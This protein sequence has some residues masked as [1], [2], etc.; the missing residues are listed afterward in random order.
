MG[1]CAAVANRHNAR[2][3]YQ[4]HTIHITINQPKNTYQIYEHIHVKWTY[5]PN[6]KKVCD[7]IKY[8]QTSKQK[9]FTDI[10]FKWQCTQTHTQRWITKLNNLDHESHR[11][12][13]QFW[14][15][16][17]ETI[18][19]VFIVF[20]FF[21]YSLSLIQNHY[22]AFVAKV[23]SLYFIL[24]GYFAKGNRYRL[25]AL[26]MKIVNTNVHS[27]WWYNCI[28]KYLH[29]ISV[30]TIENGIWFENTIQK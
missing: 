26:Y 3:S 9:L 24:F 11:N 1:S 29:K 21:S 18:Q 15:I 28:T 27:I 4:T 22:F 8:K 16:Q 14:T 23:F 2:N 13:Q 20:F 25:F 6:E 19:T 5:D 17:I 7:K 12:S 30:K 10:R